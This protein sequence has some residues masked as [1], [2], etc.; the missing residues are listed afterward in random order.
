VL[1]KVEKRIRMWK[2]VWKVL[3]KSMWLLAKEYLST[4]LV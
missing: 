3:A 4:S 2:W 1:G